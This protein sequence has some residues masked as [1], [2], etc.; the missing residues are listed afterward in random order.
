MPS[1]NQYTLICLTQMLAHSM[2]IKCRKKKEYSW[3]CFAQLDLTLN[4]LGPKIYDEP[5]LKYQVIDDIKLV[6]NIDL[7]FTMHHPK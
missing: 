3:G 2:S 5:K 4:C 7:S 6:L 1:A